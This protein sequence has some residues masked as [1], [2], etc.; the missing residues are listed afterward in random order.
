[1][2]L[3]PFAVIVPFTLPQV[4][5]VVT[6]DNCGAVELLMVALV[7]C[8]QPLASFTVTV[9]VPGVRLLNILLS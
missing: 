4:A 7:V 3:L 5:G 2:P 9:Y 8:V 1:M 6:V